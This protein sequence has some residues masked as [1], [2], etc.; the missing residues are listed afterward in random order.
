MNPTTLLQILGA[1][2][3]GLAV[4]HTFSTKFFE[5]LAHR[6]P[7]YAAMARWGVTVTAEVVAGVRDAA[8]FTD[9]I[10]QALERRRN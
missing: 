9:L 3:F 7:R 2:L 6:Q 4:L 8:G 1:L 5:T 10:A